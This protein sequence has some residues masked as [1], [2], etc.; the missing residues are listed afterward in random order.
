MGGVRR[1]M[2]D[3]DTPEDIPLE[4]K[5]SK[6]HISL[7]FLCLYS[8]LPTQ[9]AEKSRKG[10]VLFRG[11]STC[12][13]PQWTPRLHPVAIST[14]FEKSSTDCPTQALAVAWRFTQER[15]FLRFEKHIFRSTVALFGLHYQET[16]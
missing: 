4:L 15:S 3:A 2:T 13:V 14:C 10:F 8:R 6:F 5:F 9:F 11:T 12:I 1:K 7:Y 16:K